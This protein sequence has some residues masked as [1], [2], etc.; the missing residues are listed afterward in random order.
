MN[1]KKEDEILS[2]FLERIINLI[3]IRDNIH[4]DKYKYLFIQVH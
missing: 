1:K 3:Y 2:F 4:I